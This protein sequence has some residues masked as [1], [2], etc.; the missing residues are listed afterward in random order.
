MWM[1][2][3]ESL[4]ENVENFM[5]IFDYIE[6]NLIYNSLWILREKI[7]EILNK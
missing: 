3:Y 6:I 7:F 4:F 2:W 1:Y 5:S